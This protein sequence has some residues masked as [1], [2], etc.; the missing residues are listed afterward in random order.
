M[1]KTVLLEKLY[2]SPIITPRTVLR[3]MN[4]DDIIEFLNHTV[5]SFALNGTELEDLFKEKC[6]EQIS[7]DSDIVFSVR[8]LDTGS[9]IGYFELKRLDSEP[10][11]GIELMEGYQKQ[12]FGYEI[13]R[14]VIDYIFE[15][16]D[17]TVLKY[18]CFRNN[19]ASLRL[20][21]KLGAVKVNERVLFENLQKAGLSAET[22][23]ESV[24]F[25]LLI[26]DIRKY[27]DIQ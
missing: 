15:N 9:Y 21:K 18:N 10:E 11:I 2:Y 12:G 23:S 20:A 26:H 24:G 4:D 19:S 25:D 5:C 7:S 6:K 22:I 3:P 8:L 16:T 27:S 14:T 1:K 13:C 17:I